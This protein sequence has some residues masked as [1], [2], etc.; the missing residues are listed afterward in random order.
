MQL[1]NWQLDTVSGGTLRLDGGTM[2][3]VVPKMLWEKVSPPDDRNRIRMDTNCVLARD[4]VH[5]VLIDTGYG[6]KLTER[7]RHFDALESGE[8]LLKSLAALNVT[9]EQVDY[10]ALTHLHFD[11]CGGGTRHDAQGR[12]VPTFPEARYVVSKTEWQTA[13][14]G[15]PELRGSYPTENFLVLEQA[16]QLDL[17]DPLAEIV[18]GLTALPAAGHTAGHL[19]YMLR[20]QGETAIYPCDLCP[21][22][23]HVRTQWCLSY[24][25][26][27]LATR[28]RKAELLGETA[29]NGWLILW[30]HDPDVAAS[31]VIRDKKR[32]FA[33]VDRVERL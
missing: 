11:H 8:P 32:D 24:D 7:Q 33:I 12:I 23:A 19:A 27:L 3:G 17:I 21:T 26:D 25:V 20:S 15:R 9:P 28:R 31:R 30:G 10:V 4:G 14:S 22:T 29:D 18:P 5:T 13:T 6:G 16:G 2:F 1:G